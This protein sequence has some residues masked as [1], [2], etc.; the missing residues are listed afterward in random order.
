MKKI[1]FLFAMIFT[2]M[3]S[4][5]QADKESNEKGPKIKFEEKT[6]DFGKFSESNPK[7]S[8]VFNFTNVGDKPLVIPQAIAACGC[9]APSY[10][11]EP[12]MPGEKGSIKVVYNGRGRYPGF[13]KKTI[14]IRTNG[15]P[16]VTTLYIQGEMTPKE[17]TAE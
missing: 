13:F 6:H 8:C 7:V 17:E 10:T 12:V 15:T 1:L 4:Y 3:V 5:A 14:R 2:C 9:T 16:E 11:K